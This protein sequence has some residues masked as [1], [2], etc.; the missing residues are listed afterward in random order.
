MI[1]ISIQ[2]PTYN[3]SVFIREAVQSVLDQTYESKQIIVA[4]DCSNFDVANCLS[5]FK[6]IELIQ[7]QSNKGRVKNYHDTLY[8]YVKGDYFINLDGD[9]YFTDT[10]FLEYAAALIASNDQLNILF[11]QGNHNIERIKPLMNFRVLD[12]YTIVVN[13]R[14]YLLHFP[15]IGEFCH[16]ATIFHTVKSKEIGFYN[17]NC[18]YTDFNSAARLM[19]TNGDLLISSKTVA[20]W[21]KH[22]KNATWTYD[23]NTYSQEK[24]AINN[25]FK[26]LKLNEA[27]KFRKTQSDLIQNLYNHVIYSFDTQKF[28]FEHMKFMTLNFRFTLNSL[29][30]IARYILIKL[31]LKTVASVN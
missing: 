17:F 26:N 16:A 25:V 20:C 9:D 2:I 29:K 18:L 24:S 14:D 5:D 19:L 10:T 4:D 31:K 7:N 8:N 30:T 21:R 6:C 1:E 13:S 3:Q 27:N 28:K 11:F 15:S 23:K 12:E 22:D